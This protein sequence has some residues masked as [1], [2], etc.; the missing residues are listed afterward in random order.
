MANWRQLSATMFGA[1]GGMKYFGELV[2]VGVGEIG[3]HEIFWRA[4]GGCNIFEGSQGA[5]KKHFGIFY[6]KYLCQYYGM[7]LKGRGPLS[8]NY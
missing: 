5:S 3:G 8:H 1:I 6:L 7:T 4:C 2:G